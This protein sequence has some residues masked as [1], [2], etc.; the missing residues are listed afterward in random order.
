MVA[1]TVGSLVKYESGMTASLPVTAKLEDF[2]TW[3]SH[4]HAKHNQ[5]A[6]RLN[7]S[8]KNS[9]SPAQ[10]SQAQHAKKLFPVYNCVIKL[11]HSIWHL[12]EVAAPTAELIASAEFRYTCDLLDAH[13]AHQ[14]KRA[15]SDITWKAYWHT[16][17]REPGFTFT[18]HGFQPPSDG[19]PRDLADS[20]RHFSVS[21]SNDRGL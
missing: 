6:Q 16:I 13:R 18:L 17:F 20:L 7:K 9:L 3:K 11:H 12:T 21:T 19:A 1:D 15:A 4:Y 10:T 8:Q 2:P 14:A 5:N